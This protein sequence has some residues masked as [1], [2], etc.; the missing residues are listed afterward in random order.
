MHYSTSF[1]NRSLQVGEGCERIEG[2]TGTPFILRCPKRLGRVSSQSVFD[3]NL[4]R[5]LATWS[6][7]ARA[8]G[9]LPTYSLLLN[10][11]GKAFCPVVEIAFLQIWATGESVGVLCLALIE[12]AGHQVPGV[13]VILS[14]WLS[15][16][17][18]FSEPAGQTCLLVDQI[19]ALYYVHGR[20]GLQYSVC[21]T[22]HGVLHIREFSWIET[23]MREISN[24]FLHDDFFLTMK[25]LIRISENIAM[26]VQRQTKKHLLD[27]PK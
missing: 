16:A 4:G 7:R 27:I 9:R 23:P 13:G 20:R 12:L 11:Y 25:T 1:L 24:T 19:P 22:V 5:Q 17:P 26:C 3:F 15:R 6:P 2:Q 8:P 18:A 10:L 14:S 21:I